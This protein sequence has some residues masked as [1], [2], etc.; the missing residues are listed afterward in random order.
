[1]TSMPIQTGGWTCN[2]CGQFVP[3][4]TSHM[5]HIPNWGYIPPA[6]TFAPTPPDMRRIETLLEEI[7]AELRRASAPPPGPKE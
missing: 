2:I 7:L 6:P 4:G 3:H 5:C 1:M